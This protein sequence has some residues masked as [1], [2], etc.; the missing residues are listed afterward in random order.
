MK[1]YK[2]LE[3]HRVAKEFK[4]KMPSKGHLY[5][6]YGIA[7]CSSIILSIDSF[8]CT[9]EYAYQYAFCDC[10][11]NI[12]CCTYGHALPVPQAKSSGRQCNRL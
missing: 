7:L 4:E 6:Q 1:T 3:P 2:P 11:Y 8:F 5:K 9:C 10:L 12:H